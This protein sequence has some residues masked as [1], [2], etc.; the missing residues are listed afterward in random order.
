M[1]FLFF[2]CLTG[3]V[4][5]RLY[6]LQ[7]TYYDF[8]YSL[9][10]SQYKS[11]VRK[12]SERALIV[13][14]HNRPLVFN[15][16]IETAFIIRNKISDTSAFLDFLYTHFPEAAQRFCS[17]DKQFMYIKRHLN[18]LEQKI[19]RETPHMKDIYVMQE[20][21]RLC[22]FNH[23][24][25]VIGIVDIDNKG[26]MGIEYLYDA[27]L[28]GKDT[29]LLAEKDAR[30]NAHYFDQK[31]KRDGARGQT[32]IMTIDSDIQFLAYQEL[33]KTIEQFD[34][35]EG[36]VIIMN[37]SN[38]DIITSLSIPC[39]DL[40]ALRHGNNESTK[41]KP[42]TDA[43]ELG[44]VMKIFAALA[45]LDEKLVS[46]DE[47]IDCKYVTTAYVNGR[48]VNTVK[49]HGII[50][51]IDVIAKSNNIGIASVASRLGERL[52]DHYRNIGFGKKTDI[53]FPGES[54]GFLMP[55]CKWSKQSVI[56]LS[57]GYE[58]S[59]TLL[60][61][62]CAMSMIAQ[63]GVSVAPHLVCG[64]LRK[65]SPSKRIYAEQVIAQIRRILEHTTLTGTARKAIM[66]GYKVMSKTGTANVLEHGTYNPKKQIYTCAGIIEKEDYQRVI[67]VQIK[68]ILEQDVYASQVAVPLFEAIAQHVLMHDRVIAQKDYIL[69]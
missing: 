64:A 57:Y 24:R 66:H 60:Q 27:I 46:L 63:N 65:E 62:A 15:Q 33:Q 6:L 52:H 14:R 19:I 39:F 17:H 7:V 41:N 37:P 30:L 68:E 1:L 59:V 20:I 29:Y 34:A 12:R 58:V 50:P 35:K 16:P 11:L 3:I 47:P 53:E 45:A 31:I 23:L 61:L 42:I 49:A 18:T 21:A 40:T 48:R 22:L 28:A 51:F 69:Q 8:F 5:V 26:I 36:S 54:P 4:L 43:C 25:Q 38:G 32:V 2:V 9:A 55:V 67:V 56:S 44:S 13:D 10:R